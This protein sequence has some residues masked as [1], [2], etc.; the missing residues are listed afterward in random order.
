VALTLLCRS[1]GL[2]V[3]YVMRKQGWAWRD[4]LLWVM[5][6][7]DINIHRGLEK[8]LTNVAYSLPTFFTRE[9]GTERGVEKK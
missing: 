8:T 9:E 1:A 2:V 3:L 7:R 6:R 5:E 4:A